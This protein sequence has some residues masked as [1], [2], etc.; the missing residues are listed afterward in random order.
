MITFSVILPAYNNSDKLKR[1]LLS[2]QER[3]PDI[4]NHEVIVVDDGSKNNSIALLCERFPFV[5]YIRHEENH[6]VA[7]A[8]NVGARESRNDIL[9]FID[10][11]LLVQS[12]FIS[13]LSKKFE[14]KNVVAVSGTSS[15]VPANSSPFRDYWGFYKALN[16]PKGEYT[17]LFTG[18][19]GAIKKDIFWRSG[20]WDANI[21]G[22]SKEEYEF[23]ARLEKLGVKINYDPEFEL[24]PHYKGFWELIPENYR[25]AKKWCVIFLYRKKFDDYTSTFSG[26]L[27]YALGA[28]LFASGVAVLIFHRLG[29]LFILSVFLYLAATFNFWA[30]IIKK[31]GF[32]FCLL[33][34]FFHIASSLFI[35]AGAL[36]GLFYF[37]MPDE[38]RRRAIN[39]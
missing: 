14:D 26:G 5:K 7:N 31:R 36:H 25:R 39:S 22:V 1:L 32:F 33:S 38:A 27:T 37:F 23:T 21:K 12:D 6:G 20:G 3:C 16:M 30:F 35:F 4:G 15:A 9:V 24:K 17:T 11:D 2:I 34:V 8:R 13:I 29:I 19:Q 10:S 18:Q 28:F